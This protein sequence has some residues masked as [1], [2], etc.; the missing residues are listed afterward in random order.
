MRNEQRQ[1]VWHGFTKYRDRLITVS[2]LDIIYMDGG[3]VTD[4]T[5]PKDVDVVI[6]F[7]D[8]ATLIR[9]ATAHRYLRERKYVKDA[10]KVDIVA[11][12]PALPP[13]VTEDMR[14]FFQRLRPEDAI[15][16]GLSPDTK[17]GI[18]KLSIR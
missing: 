13:G 9:L 1:K 7:P 15:K 12:F 10:Y 6:E 14:D 2:E 18:L 4:S 5:S 3:F 17:K 16:R 8:V 11:C